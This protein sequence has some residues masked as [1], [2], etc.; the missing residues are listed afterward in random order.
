VLGLRY[1]QLLPAKEAEGSY[2]TVETSS[3][4]EASTPPDTETSPEADSPSRAE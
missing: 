4:K 3:I 1:M 2:A